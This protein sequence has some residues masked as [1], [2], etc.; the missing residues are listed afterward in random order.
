M[1]AFAFYRLYSFP[2]SLFERVLDPALCQP[3]GDISKSELY[4]SGEHY[5]G[6]STQ[7][8]YDS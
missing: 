1:R 3:P 4:D 8:V 2:E 6:S 7:K 5:K